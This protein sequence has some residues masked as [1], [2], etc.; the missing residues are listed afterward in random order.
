MKNWSRLIWCFSTTLICSFWGWPTS[1][2][3]FYFGSDQTLWPIGVVWQPS[4]LHF[5]V[6]KSKLH[7]HTW[8]HNIMHRLT[9][10]APKWNFLAN[11]HLS[12]AFL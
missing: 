5:R 6:A 1:P 8:K 12:M 9:W 7:Q 2:P 11:N 3:S 4:L 10:V